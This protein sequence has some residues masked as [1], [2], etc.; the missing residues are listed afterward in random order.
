MSI[1]AARQ[2]LAAALEQVIETEITQM[3]IDAANAGQG[4]PIQEFDAEF[5][6]AHGIPR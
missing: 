6:E 2:R 4:R 5:R 3:A 1:K